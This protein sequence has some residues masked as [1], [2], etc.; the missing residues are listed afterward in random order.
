MTHFCQAV[1]DTISIISSVHLKNKIIKT[2][3]K[4]T[5]A[6]VKLKLYHVPNNKK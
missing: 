4:R 5:L 2:S 6:I 1:L 3:F